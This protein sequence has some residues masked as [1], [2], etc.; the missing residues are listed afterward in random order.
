MRHGPA[1]QA[2]RLCGRAGWCTSQ[3]SARKAKPCFRDKGFDGNQTSHKCWS[4]LKSEGLEGEVWKIKE[5][6][7]ARPRV[8]LIE[9]SELM[10]KSEKLGWAAPR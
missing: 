3:G 1:Q 2:Q 6:S 4:R 7:P 10:G 9:K 8:A 5:G